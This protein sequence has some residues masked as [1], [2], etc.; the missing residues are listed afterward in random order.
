VKLKLTLLLL[1][2]ALIRN[3]IGAQIITT[4]AGTGTPGYSGNGGLSTSAQLSFP[5]GVA[6]DNTGKIYIADHDN[7]VIR[8]IN[9]AGII[10]NFAGNATSG[11][12]GDGGP[13]TAAQLANPS[14]LTCDNAGNLYFTDQDGNVIR[15]IDPSGIITTIT[16]NLGPGYSGDGGPL[17]LARFRNISGITIDV[18]GNMYISDYGSNVVRKVNTAGIITTFAGSGAQGYG[19]DGGPAI[20]ASLNLV[21]E[22][23]ADNAGNIYVPDAGN[24]R[25]RK[26]NPAG[27]ISTWAG[28]GIG[29]YSGDGGPATAASLNWPWHI[30]IDNADNIYVNETLNNI[31]RKI[32]PAGIVSTFAGNGTQGYS[33]DG[34]P[35]IAAQL[36]DVIGIAT[37]NA[38]NVYTVNRAFHVLRKI[39]ACLT[40]SITQQPVNV[41]LCNT[42]NANF[43]ITATNLTSYQWQVNTGTGWN[44][45]TDNAIYSGSTTTALAITGATTAM[46]NYQYRCLVTNACGSIPSLS[47]SLII[48]PPS[49]PAVS[50]NTITPVICTGSIASFSATPSNAGP[51]PAYQWT[52][53][54]TNVGTNSAFY[55][56]NNLNNGDII[57]CTLTSASSCV[58]T[59]TA[60]SNPITMTVNQPVTA[61]VSITASTDNVCYGTPITFTSAITNGGPTPTYT[62]FRNATNL[63]LNSPTYTDNTLN[64]GDWVM[65]VMRTSIACVASDIVISN[66]IM[67]NITALATSS[68]TIAASS[69]SFC[70]GSTATFTATPNNGGTSPSYQWMKNNMAVGININSYTDNTIVTGDIITCILTPNTSCPAS[71]TVTSNALPVT[72]F[73]NPVVNLDPTNTLC[74]GSSRRLDAGN[75]SSYLWNDG[76]TERSITINGTGTY[77]VMVTDQNGCRGSAA[78]QI[79]TLLPLPAGFL[80]GDTSICSYGSLVLKAAT[81]YRNYLWNNNATGFSLTITQPGLYWLEVTDNNNCKGK[82]SVTVA[83]KDCMKGFYIPNAFTPNGDGKNDVFRPLLFGNAKQY[84]FSVYNRWGEIVFQTMQPAKGWDGNFRGVKQDSHVFTWICMY[85]LEGEQL[86]TEK[87]TVVVVR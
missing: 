37:D 34:G 25:I 74:T 2:L 20:S 16:G 85:Q 80:P 71:P 46:N 1:I 19:G 77:Q 3:E 35:A 21:Y 50:I 83:P 28:N 66:P 63:F 32:T 67:V 41:T 54:G 6:T 55:T 69:P 14:Y 84:K 5:M 70:E 26:V 15:K 65:C 10:S 73:Q 22:V 47:G 60:T 17:M 79:T 12:S 64:N 11:Y 68:V 49:T 24:H 57:S 52:R 29:G 30:A 51:S 86:K 59:A 61:V 7:N 58:T 13:A 72:V 4:I 62:W 53:N 48:N 36:I 18:A 38:G 78:T 33:G 9:N 27:I 81:G 87:G 75:F 44:I 40:V 39:T 82:D 56:D 8:V 76:S 31:V 23:V 43:S 45:I 42:G